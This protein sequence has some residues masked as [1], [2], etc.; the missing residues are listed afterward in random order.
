V[1]LITERG[2]LFRAHHPAP[3]TAVAK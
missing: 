3:R 2:K 1:V